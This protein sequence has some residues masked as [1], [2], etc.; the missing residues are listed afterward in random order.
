MVR[1]NPEEADAVEVA[2]ASRAGWQLK[3]PDSQSVYALV[4]SALR[5]RRGRVETQLGV[6]FHSGQV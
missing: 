2:R 5:W 1:D 6:A 3:I 4:N